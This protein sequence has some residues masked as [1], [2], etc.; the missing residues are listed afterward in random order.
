M[1]YKKI[2]EI[3]EQS[4]KNY[5]FTGLFGMTARHIENYIYKLL[6][7]YGLGFEQAGML[8]LLSCRKDLQLNDIVKESLKDKTTISRAISSLE[9]KGFITK[10]HSHRDKRIVYINIAQEGK[11][12]LQELTDSTI[13]SE[14]E[15][16]FTNALTT[17][18]QEIFKQCLTKILK[19]ML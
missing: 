17:E 19:G 9:K 2:K 13:F 1:S 15:S 4:L 10:T 6:Q 18:E 14:A 3:D 16:I 5:R 12:K 11:D 7:P 8:F